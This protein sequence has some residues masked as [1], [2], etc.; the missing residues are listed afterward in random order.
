MKKTFWVP[1][2][3]ALLAYLLLPLPGL[4]APLVAA[5]RREALAAR[6]A[7]RRRRACS[8]PRSR[9]INTAST[10]SRAR[11]RPRS[12]ASA[13]VQQS[14]DQQKKQLLEVRNRLEAARDRL[15]RLRSELATARRVLAARLVEIYKADSPDALTVILEADGFGDLLERAEFLDR[16]SDQDRADHRPGARA[17]RQG[18]GPGR[19][20]REPRA[21]RAARGRADP[22]RARPDRRRGEPAPVA[23]ATS[24][25]RPRA[26]RRGAL[27]Q[28]R[29]QPRA[30]SRATSPRSRPSRPAWQPRHPGRLGRHLQAGQRAADLAGERPGRVAL[31]DA[32]GPAA[33][34]H[35]HRGSRRHADPRRRLAAAWS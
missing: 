16:I 30:A 33:R 5:H 35:R 20:A 8:P 17:A 10:G 7:R 6:Q 15:E 12:A 21:A 2:T 31:R 29:R 27:A 11:S 32:L 9:A 24:S 23:R 14:L 18:G 1:I 34:R 26:D 13:R 3:L 22:A 19:P 28:V 4:S 25:P